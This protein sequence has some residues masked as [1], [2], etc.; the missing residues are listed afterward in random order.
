MTKI[1]LYGALLGL[2][3]HA[4]DTA[5]SDK[6]KIEKKLAE[7]KAQLFTTQMIA[8]KTV[9][10]APYSALAVN[11]T[12]QVL[13]DGNRIKRA[14]STM[15]YRDSQG[16]ERREESVGSDGVP[17]SILISDPSDGVT[18]WVFKVPAPRPAKKSG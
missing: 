13:A 5:D 3:L 14:S 11:E 16:R 10:G 9:K 8:G 12:V 6:A 2:S 4:Q 7:A 15:L 17:R 1:A 18:L